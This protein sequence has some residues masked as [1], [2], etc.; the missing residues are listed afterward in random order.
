[1]KGVVPEELL[2]DSLPSV[3]LCKDIQYVLQKVKEAMLRRIPPT[4]AA[5]KKNSP[6]ISMPRNRWISGS[7]TN[8]S[9][10]PSWYHQVFP[11]FAEYSCAVDGLAHGKSCCYFLFSEA[12]LLLQKK[13]PTS[14][15]ACV[16][17]SEKS[18]AT[19]SFTPYFRSSLQHLRCILSESQ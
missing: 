10:V 8:S 19:K 5:F 17:S 4:S 14:C 6:D 2:C 16:A 9:L 13:V 3:N 15:N 11:E 7:Y 12:T 1:M 18:R